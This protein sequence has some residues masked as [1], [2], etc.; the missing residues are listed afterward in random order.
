MI[1]IYK[2]T[3]PSGKI[4]VGQTID[5]VKRF[6]KYSSL[7]C[8]AQTRLYNSFLKYGYINHIIEIIEECLFEEL[9]IKERYWQ[10]YY[11]VIGKNGLNCI[12]TETNLLPKAMSKET[13]LKIKE[14]CKNKII[15]NE[16]K[17]KMSI[18]R[19][20]KPHSEK[21]KLALKI[22][23]KNKGMKHSDETKKIWSNQRKDG[24]HP[25]AKRIICTKTNKVWETITECAKDNDLKITTLYARL[26]GQNKNKTTLKFYTDENPK[27]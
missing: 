23:G 5:T 25:L 12:L 16:A 21:H 15:S 2:I 24:K 20:G 6:N 7:N 1:G 13:I 3:S 22:K 14:S 27:L 11:N 4:Y 19:K 9:N 26:S 8:K 17:Q 18:S 10:D